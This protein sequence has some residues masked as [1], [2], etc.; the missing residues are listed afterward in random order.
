MATVIL[1]ASHVTR[2]RSRSLWLRF[3]KW[4][5]QPQPIPFVY[6]KHYGH[7][8]WDLNRMELVGI[9]LVVVDF[10]WAVHVSKIRTHRVSSS[11]VSGIDSWVK[12]RP[13]PPRP[14]NHRVT[15][16]LRLGCAEEERFYL[17]LRHHQPLTHWPKAPPAQ[18]RSSGSPHLMDALKQ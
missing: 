11:L 16:A 4:I 5:N 17:T 10:L 9:D 13:D 7:A 2:A 15:G 12:S 6:W 14:V 3:R 1:A 8:L 18:R